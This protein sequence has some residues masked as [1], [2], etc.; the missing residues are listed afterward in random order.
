MCASIRSR[1]IREKFEL[2][3]AH[4]AYLKSQG[5][6]SF[7]IADQMTHVWIKALHEGIKNLHPDWDDAQILDAMRQKVKDEKSMQSTRRQHKNVRT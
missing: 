6:T 5:L 3:Q 7:Q 1:H 2:D 4:I